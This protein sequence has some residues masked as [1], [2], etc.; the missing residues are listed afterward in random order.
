MHLKVVEYV[1]VFSQD[2]TY[3]MAKQNLRST[4][5]PHSVNGLE[6]IY[7]YVHLFRIRREICEMFFFLMNSENC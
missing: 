5:D 3:T 6:I 7:M 4:C 1:W 2:I